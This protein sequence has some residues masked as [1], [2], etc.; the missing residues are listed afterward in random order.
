MDKDIFIIGCRGLPASYGGYETFVEQ[1]TH[2]RKNEHIHYHVACRTS[3]KIENNERFEYNNA[4]CFK[5][6]VPQIGPAQPIYYDLKAVKNSVQYVKQHNIVK[7]IFY[8]L[9]CSV[10][11]FVIRMKRLIASVDGKIFIN[12]DGH[13]WM[14]AKW[15]LFA[16]KYLKFSE[17]IMVKNADL[18]ICDSDSI[19][20]YIQ[21]SYQKFEPVTTFIAYGANITRSNLKDDDQIFLNWLEKFDLK[22][23]EYYLIVGRFVPENNYETMIREFMKSKTN[24]DLIIIT[25]VEQNSFYEKLKEET[26]FTRD[27]RVKFVGT[28]Y[29]E[30]LLKKIREMS[31]AYL[32]GHSVGGTNPSLLEA[33]ASTK[34]NLL[35]NVG[36]NSEVAAK[37]A[38]Y[39]SLKRG[40]LSNLINN[41]EK[42]T[43][44][45]IHE[46]DKKSTDRIRKYY[47]WE[48]IVQQ[49]E[50]VFYRT[51]L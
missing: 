41:A 43:D 35:Y 31:F 12:P 34:V 32:H 46:L 42:L 9:G 8:V 38:W 25:N 5:V 19:E 20:K 11:P 37:G 4:D 15:G 24:K 28:V 17:Q 13:E 51:V 7:P 14:R 26:K 23:H 33:L 10:G 45:E 39:W 21:K 16:R 29:N 40:H 18:V 36:F 48:K 22:K 27:K 2:G 50:T 6:F 49:Y 1:L 30:N 44:N 47:S 3:S